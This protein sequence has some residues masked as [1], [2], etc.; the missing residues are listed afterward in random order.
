[1]ARQSQ[2]ATTLVGGVIKATALVKSP[3]SI[4]GGSALTCNLG[5]VTLVVRIKGSLSAG[6]V[7]KLGTSADGKPITIIS[8]MRAS[9]AGTKPIILAIPA[10]QAQHNTIIET[11]PIPAAGGTSS[12]DTTS[13]FTTII[14]KVMTSGMGAPTEITAAVQNAT[15]HEKHGVT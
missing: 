4:L 13:L 6:T 12:L 1:M 2:V 3:I 5:K 7:L 10:G 11:I 9:G 8:A 15:G 14:T